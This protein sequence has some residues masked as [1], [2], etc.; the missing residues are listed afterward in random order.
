MLG[1]VTCPCCG[2]FLGADFDPEMLRLD[3]PPNLR[4]LFDHLWAEPKGLD[5]YQLAILFY[6]ERRGRDRRNVRTLQ[7][8]ISNLRKKLA[9]WNVPLTKSQGVPGVYRIVLKGKR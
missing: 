2:T 6:G 1:R 3:L 9:R 4:V 8:Q 5:R 7:V